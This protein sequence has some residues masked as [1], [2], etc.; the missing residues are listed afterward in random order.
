MKNKLLTFAT[1]HKFFLLLTGFIPALLFTPSLLFHNKMTSWDLVGHIFVSS[2]IKDNLFPNPDGWIPFQSLGYSFGSYYPP[3]IHYLVAALSFL[4][5]NPVFWIKTLFLLAVLM[6]PFSIY[7]LTKNIAHLLFKSL[8]QKGL[9]LITQASFLIIL[10]GPALYGGS[11]K[12]FLQLGLM[13]NFFTFPLLLFYIGIIIQFCNPDSKFDIKKILICSLLLSIIMLS[14]LV[15]GF[16]AL[17][18]TLTFALYR[19]VKDIKDKK[20]LIKSILKSPFLLLLVISFFSVLFFYVNYL[21]NGSYISTPETIPSDSKITLILT[22]SFF[23]SLALNFKNKLINERFKGL[24]FSL[25]LILL[26]FT[27]ISIFEYIKNKLDIPINL[28]LIQPYR[29]L[30]IA[31]Y[32]APVWILLNAVAFYQ[33]FLSKN[34]LI[35]KFARTILQNKAVF[36]LQ[37]ILL[38]VISLGVFVLDLGQKDYGTFRVSENTKEISGNVFTMLSTQDSYYLYRTPYYQPLN[39]NKR[40]FYSEA[41]FIESSYIGPYNTA[42][43]RALSSNTNIKPAF[44]QLDPETYSISSQKA[45]QLIALMN[46]KYIVFSET[47]KPEQDICSTNSTK[48]YGTFINR[49]G[50][51]GRELYYCKVN[52]AILPK[53][54]N[55]RFVPSKHWKEESALWL[56]KNASE[57]YVEKNSSTLPKE[58]HIVVNQHELKWQPDYQG[59]TVENTDDGISVVPVTFSPKWKAYVQ[60]NGREEEVNILRVSPSLLALDT[61]GVII[62]KYQSSTVEKA[63]KIVSIIFFLINLITIILLM[64]LGVKTL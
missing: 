52:T 19:L 4:Y 23:I 3:L 31:L 51:E 43:E 22:G 62:F 39:Q 34:L 50:K 11:I 8:P 63:L 36:I 57:A 12:S 44:K 48:E 41:Q 29:L 56:S 45:K 35:Q 13:G 33:N 18:F 5:N 53:S 17:V 60:A 55:V 27:L 49:A 58:S 2:F 24:Y 1:L 20:N 26:T 64:T 14:H 21:I 9:I 32:L 46:I 47:K 38:S 25:T 7:F 59:F 10:F 6:L 30:S 42:L 54:F 15:T 40:I 61:K 37:L 16:V 28:G